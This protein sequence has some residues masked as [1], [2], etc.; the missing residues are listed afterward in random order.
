VL[1]PP[2]ETT[3]LIETYLIW[4]ARDLDRNVGISVDSYSVDQA[5]DAAILFRSTI[6]R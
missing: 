5:D 4:E 3:R 6:D 2:L 1:H